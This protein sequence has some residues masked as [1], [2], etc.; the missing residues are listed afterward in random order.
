VKV[1]SD[2]SGVGVLFFGM[3]YLLLLA[4]LFV[5]GGKVIGFL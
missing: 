2:F 3:T 1:R 4:S 5:A